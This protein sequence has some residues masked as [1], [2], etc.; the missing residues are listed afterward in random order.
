M[1]GPART[2]IVLLSTLVVTLGA[3]SAA[4]ATAITPSVFTD[5]AVVNGNCT[6]REAIR[7]ANTDRAQDACPAGSGVDTIQLQAGT[8]SL[9][10]A[11]DG[12]GDGATGDLDVRSNLTIVGAGPRATVL[13]GAWS[14]NPDRLIDVP[15][16]G[17]SVLISGITAR[18]GASR[19]QGGALFA[20][21]R[22]FVTVTD[23]VFASNTAAFG[24]ALVNRGT[25]TLNR[26][27][28]I[29]NTATRCCA[30]VENENVA[31][32]TDVLIANN[33]TPGGD[34]G[35]FGDDSSTLTNVTAVGNSAARYGAGISIDGEATLT[36]VTVSGNSMQDVGSGGVD[37]DTGPAT[38]NNV[39]ITGNIVDAD[40]DGLGDGG[41][42]FVESGA[43]VT[44]QNTIVAGNTDR[45]GQAPDC[46]QETGT[47]LVSGGH[48]L[49]GTT[50]GCNFVAGPGDLTEVD[51]LLGP[52]SDNGG[53][54]T[55]HSLLPGSPAIDGGDQ[56]PAGSGG[57]SCAI[58]DQ[59][60]LL[61][62]CDIGSYELYLCGDVPV[63]RI[64]TSGDDTLTGTRGADGFLGGAGNDTATGRGGDDAFC[65]GRGRDTAI[66]NAGSDRALGGDGNDTVWGGAGNDLLQDEQ[67]RDRLYG[68]AGK[69]R[70]AGGGGKD[71]LRCGPGR[72]DIV[73]GRRGDA[74]RKCERGNP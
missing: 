13:E 27:R 74:I 47:G 56:S 51:P 73:S 63:N 53:L 58:A 9:T 24:G 8:Y 2:A 45:G 5:D 6:L 4:G 52:L 7:A 46:A 39:T 61:R 41:G 19:D 38:L 71:R 21:P 34:G 22:T 20:R 54:A 18:R 42:L 17:T 69:D 11:G 60:G 29:G 36:N 12:E 48:N 37:I 68:G 10:V 59:R 55:T 67:G 16:A 23:S 31:T 65:L 32:L 30:G 33:V 62:T 66:G 1:N 28:V 15:V 3:T 43:P 14:S 70:L 25:L 35:Y 26:V 49:I 72:K 64:G 50:A 40:N 57:A 44:V